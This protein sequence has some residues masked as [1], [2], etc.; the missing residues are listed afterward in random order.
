MADDLA[1]VADELYAMPPEDFVEAR[2]ARAKQ[3]R[4]EGDRELAT[5][6]RELPKPTA[7]A[8]LLNQL[9]RL[10]PD[11]VEQLVGLGDELREAQQSLDGDQMRALNQQR[12]QVV[13][14]F[15]RQAAQ[16]ADELGRP[17]S[18]AVAQQVQETLR[19][20]VADAEAG[21]A[22]LS[23]RL[24]TALSYVGMGEV[25][26][27]AAVA[28]PKARRSPPRT[29]SRK[30]AAPPPPDDEV[31]AARDRRRETARE[32]LTEAEQQA[33]AAAGVLA[34]TEQRVRELQDA[35]AAVTERLEALRA[36]LEEVQAEAAETDERQHEATDAH[37]AAVTA[38]EEA[39]AAVE[40][41]R[42]E[43]DELG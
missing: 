14:A 43:L 25:S 32:A 3:A 4:A 16:L 24:T 20:A 28:V 18:D 38:A 13:R 7:A 8:W 35:H 36:E 17:L 41:A 12:Q 6:V 40:R 22:L 26:V 39:A 37:D 2:D 30:H 5:E 19:A 15:A 10:R 21:Q 34:E 23:G 33:E 31:A 27:T 29:A 11:E 1:E 9:A 42:E